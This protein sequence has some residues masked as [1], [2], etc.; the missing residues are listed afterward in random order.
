MNRPTILHFDTRNTN[1]A[2]LSPRCEGISYPAELPPLDSE[3]MA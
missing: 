2:F 3:I 1:D